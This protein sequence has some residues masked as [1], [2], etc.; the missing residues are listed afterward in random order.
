MIN[1]NEINKLAIAKG[2]RT[3][4]I[5]KDWVLGHFVDAIFSIPECRKNL[6]FK[7]GTCL[8]KCWLPD[9]RFSEDIDFTSRNDSFVLDMPLLEKITELV[10]N[11]TEMPLNIQSLEKLYF[12]DSLTGYSAHIRYWGAN[13]RKDQQPPEPARWLTSI[14]IEIILYEKLF[15][16]TEK[17]TVI[18]PYSDK[19][20]E[21]ANN[22][23]VYNIYEVLA[24]KIRAL[25][26]RSYSAP[27]DYYDIWYLSKYVDD[28]DWQSVIQAFYVKSEYKKLQ[29]TGIEQLI[30]DQKDKILK[31]AWKNSLEH[32]IAFGK[33]PDYSTVREDLLSLFRK[34]FTN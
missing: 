34:V 28:I 17:G 14:K 11:R 29:F 21:N 7:G 33:L 30:N 31:T 10:T 2:V 23:P 26:Q 19:L 16:E 6:I 15:F 18:H 13:H 8:K 9:Y 5:D 3:S 1:K 27:R 24:E 20:T 25:I 22:I 4:T 12:N 32:Q